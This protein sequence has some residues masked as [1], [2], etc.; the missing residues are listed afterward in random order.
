MEKNETK[1][2][3]SIKKKGHLGRRNRFEVKRAWNVGKRKTTY[4]LNVNWPLYYYT[5]TAI[6]VR[7]SGKLNFMLLG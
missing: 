6:T 1:L 7:P 2:S 3:D 5:A 4:E